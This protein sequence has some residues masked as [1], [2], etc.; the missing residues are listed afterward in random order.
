MGGRGG[1]GGLVGVGRA[2]EKKRLLVNLMQREAGNKVGSS[3]AA[4]NSFQKTS[5][6][7]PQER[8]SK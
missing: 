3:Q 1:G 2:G 5:A 8:N 6:G 4:S 7:T